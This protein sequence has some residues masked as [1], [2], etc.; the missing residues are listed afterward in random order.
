MSKKN[1]YGEVLEEIET[2]LWEHDIRVEDKIA[3]PYQY[4]NNEFRACLKIFM[5]AMM[6]KLWKKMEGET[7]ETKAEKANQLGNELREFILKYT[8][9]DTLKLYEFEASNRT[10]NKV[11]QTT[12]KGAGQ[13]WRFN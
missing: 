7:I 2:G 6:W 10:A 9:V 5:S 13:N 1:P 12:P 8:G 3:E 4:S 11:L